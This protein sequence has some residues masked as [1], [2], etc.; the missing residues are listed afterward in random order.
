MQLITRINIHVCANKKYS[1]ITNCQTVYIAL[2]YW[3]PFWRPS[4]INADKYTF[5]QVFT[6]FGSHIGGHFGFVIILLIGLCGKCYIY[7]T[8]FGLYNRSKHIHSLWYKISYISCMC[9]DAHIGGHLGYLN[10]PKDGKVA[11][12]GF[13]IRGRNDIKTMKKH[14]RNIQVGPLADRLYCTFKF[15]HYS[16]MSDILDFNM[17]S[18][19]K[20]SK[21]VITRLLVL[22]NI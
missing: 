20:H 2:I 21:Y 1:V 19:L 15:E 16:L 4:E 14:R 7:C 5:T 3:R 12:S 17:E 11:S 8:P 6:Y 10:F 22:S 9:V 13:W 18:M